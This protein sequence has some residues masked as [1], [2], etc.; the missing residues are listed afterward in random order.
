MKPTLL[1][2]AAGMG[3][4][5]GSLKQMDT[6]GPN[7]EALIEYSI[8]D[9]LRAGFGKVV[10]VI[11]K[12]IATDFRAFFEP[13]LQGHLEIAYVYQELDNVPAGIRVPEERQKPWGT[14]HAVMVA[15]EAIQEPFAVINADDFYGKD[16]YQVL[17]SFLQQQEA[18]SE[19]YCMGGYHLENTLSEH[20][21]VARGIC[22]VDTEG[23]LTSI[24]ER[25]KIKRT[26]SGII[27]NTEE[28]ATLELPPRSITSMNMFGFTP[29]IFSHCERFFHTFI[30]ENS[31]NLK[32]EF[33]IPSVVNELIKEG[34]A[35]VKVLETDAKWFG[36]TYRE[37]KEKAKTEIANLIAEGVYPA[38]LW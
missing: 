19:T 11:R 4:R 38:E 23:F 10:F 24:V 27:K 14:G 35:Q 17:S 21:T 7:G 20:G 25:T 16:A 8:Y 1:V 28:T 15:K 18:T 30:K 26:E 31:Q 9:A 37:D 34:T 2:L 3:S 22:S 5:Y 33:Y 13:K 32:A 6:F 12:D 29:Q 36:V